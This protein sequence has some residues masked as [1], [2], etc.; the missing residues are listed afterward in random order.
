MPA[1]KSYSAK[2]K[3][4][5]VG[6]AIS[7]KSKKAAAREFR[8]DRR[9]VQEWCKQKDRLEKICKSRKRLPGGGRKVPY[10]DI[11]VKLLRW[12]QERREEGVR[13]TG[14]ALKREGLRLHSIFGNQD[15]KA[16]HGWFCNFKRRNGISL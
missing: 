10:A 6:F 14:K 3:L 13:V 4:K 16:S 11:E 15:F 7:Q 8:V 5:V 1:H 12:M 2:F 9:R